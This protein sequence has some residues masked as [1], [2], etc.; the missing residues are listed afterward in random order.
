LKKFRRGDE[1]QSKI[2][3]REQKNMKKD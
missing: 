3:C 1:E 2:L